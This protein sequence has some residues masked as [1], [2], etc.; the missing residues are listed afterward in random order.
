MY[1]NANAGSSPKR[2]LT[3]WGVWVVAVLRDD[4]EREKEGWHKND[5]LPDVRKH[6]RK[7]GAPMAVAVSL[8]CDDQYDWMLFDYRAITRTTFRGHVVKGKARLLGF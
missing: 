1:V 2:T 5:E 6:G 7:Q 3:G 4:E 8:A